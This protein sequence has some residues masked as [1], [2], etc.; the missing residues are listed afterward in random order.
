MISQFVQIRR[1]SASPLKWHRSRCVGLDKG[2]GKKGP[3]SKRHIHVL[4]PIGKNYH[5]GMM[6]K[7]FQKEDVLKLFNLLMAVFWDDVVKVQF[8]QSWLFHFGSDG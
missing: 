6:V 7:Q 2:N 1:T 4:D 5:K 8:L 3:S